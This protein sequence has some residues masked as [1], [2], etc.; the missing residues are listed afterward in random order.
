MTSP[1]H[2]AEGSKLLSRAAFE[3]VLD[4]EIRRALRTQSFLGLVVV[5]TFHEWDGV[6]VAA[7]DGTVL[8]MAEIVGTE[9]RETDLLGRCNAER[10]RSCSSTRIRTMRAASWIV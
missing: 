6:M 4:G 2:Y 8:R 7:D 9:V 1:S 3:S 10:W 5:E